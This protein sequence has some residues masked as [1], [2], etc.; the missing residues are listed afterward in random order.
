[1]STKGSHAFRLWCLLCL[2]TMRET[3]GTWVVGATPE[4]A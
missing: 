2:E 4:E 3:Q 1:M